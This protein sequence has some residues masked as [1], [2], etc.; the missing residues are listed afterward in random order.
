M[1]KKYFEAL[2]GYDES[3]EPTGHEDH[4]LIDRAKALGLK[5][6]NVQIENFLHYLSN[7][8][9]EKAENCTKDRVNYYDLEAKNRAR[10]KHNIANDILRA[11]PGGWGTLPLYKNFSREAKVY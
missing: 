2:G 7:T 5:Y 10:S 9:R 3:F 4:D 6:S 8:T 11:N 1:M